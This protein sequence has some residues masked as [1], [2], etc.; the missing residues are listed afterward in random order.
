MFPTKYVLLIYT[1]ASLFPCQMPQRVFSHPSRE[2]P[3][4]AKLS[5]LSQEPEATTRIWSL[6]EGDSSMLNECVQS[7]SAEIRDHPPPL[8]AGII[9]LLWAAEMSHFSTDLL[10]PAPSN[11]LHQ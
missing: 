1:P 5:S 3:T 7:L 8:L 4:L 2:V 11:L 10:F 9:A 6:K